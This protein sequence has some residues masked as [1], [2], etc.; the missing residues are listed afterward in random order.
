MDRRRG[1]R[2]VRF[3]GLSDAEA[4]STGPSIITTGNLDSPA[5]ARLASPAKN[6]L[7]KEDKNNTTPG[8]PRSALHPDYPMKLKHLESALC[9]VEVFAKPKV[10]LEQYIT[11]PHLAA[12]L[13]LHM[14][15]D[16]NVEG[17]NI[18]DL[19]CGTGMLGIGCAVLG[20]GQ[21]TGVDLDPAALAIASENVAEFELD[22]VVGLM[23]GDVRKTV[24]SLRRGGMF[25]TAVTNPPFGTK[26]NAG[27]D[28]LFLHA[29][30][31][32][33]TRA[34]VLSKARSW[35]CKARVV[36]ELRYNL[37]ASYKFHKKASKDIAVDF[38][39]VESD[40][41]PLDSQ[42]PQAPAQASPDSEDAP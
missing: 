10:Q 34:H 13:L 9:G 5:S 27:L 32:S 29:A 19:G 20:A 42:G 35:G 21:V 16:G 25:D 15:E 28:M 38:I 26:D 1:G 18:L 36:A 33:S 37:D 22:G 7:K 39:C 6:F 14:H 8:A 31:Q 4:T 17:C 23:L 2:G 3:G 12:Q 24:P 30:V 40:A 41:D 11:P